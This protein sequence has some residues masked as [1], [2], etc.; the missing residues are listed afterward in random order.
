MCS[1]FKLTVDQK[2]ADRQLVSLGLS[3]VNKIQILSGLNTGD[4]IIISVT[5]NWDEHQQIM[6]H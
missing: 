2:F 4:E 1:L 5:K 6:I 3:S